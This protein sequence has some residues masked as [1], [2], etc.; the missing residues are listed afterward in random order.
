MSA[1]TTLFSITPPDVGGLA[2]SSKTLP[3][4]FAV[5]PAWTF[6]A[7]PTVTVLPSIAN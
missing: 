3:V 5:N 2:V 6:G 7:P 1:S 4:P